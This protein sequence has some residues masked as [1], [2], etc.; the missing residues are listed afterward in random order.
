MRK[1]SPIGMIIACIFMLALLSAC[2]SQGQGQN[3]TVAQSQ[4]DITYTG[5]GGVTLAGTLLIPAHRQGTRVP[6]AIIVAG[7]GPTD[8]NGN[9]QGYTTDLYSQLADQLAQQ[10]I[11]SLRYDKRGVGAS[12]PYPMPKDPSSPTAAE[13]KALQDFFAW[14]NYVGDAEATLKALQQQ[15]EIDP[16]RTALI[17]HSEGSIIVEEVAAMS[18]GLAHPP[19][20]MVLISAPGR[21]VDVILREQLAHAYAKDPSIPASFVLSKYDEIIAGLR[22]NGQPPA[23]A[24]ADLQANKQVPAS[25]TQG[26]E[27]L[28]QPAYDEFWQGELQVDPAAMVRRYPGPVL[29]LQGASD[30]QVFATEDTPLLDAA[31]KTRTPDDHQVT[32]I[33]NTSHDM[34][35][36]QDPQTD[37]GISGPVVAECSQTL[38]QWLGKKLATV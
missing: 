32:I 10:G 19:A 35:Y 25:V 29:V 38:R 4:R 7:S 30:I 3:S 22:Q 13:I 5:V 15:P 8:R 12:T 2:G 34:K 17:G 18:Q 11:A 28:F 33:P 16:A 6:G 26:L 14:N 21:P 20:A 24:F 36:V 9:Q 1:R 37:P 31:L 23:S 27:V